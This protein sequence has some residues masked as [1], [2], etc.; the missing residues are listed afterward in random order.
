[1]YDLE[2]DRGETKNVAR[3]NHDIV[4][5]LS[6]KYFEWAKRTGVVDFATL[7]A[8][9]PQQMKDYRK[10]KMQEIVVPGPNF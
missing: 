3:D 1:L 4:S 2:A 10:S 6:E 7:E 5:R 8:K 9:E